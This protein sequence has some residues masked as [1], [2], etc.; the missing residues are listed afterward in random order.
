MT[1]YPDHPGGIMKCDA[2]GCTRKRRNY[3]TPTEREKWA[4]FQVGNAVIDLCPAHKSD[5]KSVPA[6]LTNDQGAAEQ[7]EQQMKETRND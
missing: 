2:P 3:C 4:A 5:T 7:A 6:W 1:W